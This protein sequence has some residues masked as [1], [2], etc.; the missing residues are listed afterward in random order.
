[1]ANF[2]E[3]FTKHA[4][5]IKNRA[6]FEASKLQKSNELSAEIR[7]LFVRRDQLYL[8]VGKKTLELVKQGKPVNQEMENAL[9]QKTGLELQ[10]AIKQQHLKTVKEEVWENPA[11]AS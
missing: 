6:M 10:I 7:A 4:N 9:E 11:P 5:E 1:M 3:T 2:L 8:E